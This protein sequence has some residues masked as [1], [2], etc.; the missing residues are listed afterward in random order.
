MFFDKIL[1]PLASERNR[2]KTLEEEACQLKSRV[3]YL[4]QKISD[5]T[6]QIENL[7]E[8]FGESTVSKINEMERIQKQLCKTLNS[9]AST[10]LNRYHEAVNELAELNAL[11]SNTV[12]VNH[13]K[14]NGI[15][16]SL[17][18]LVIFLSLPEEKIYGSVR[19]SDNKFSNILER[20]E[21]FKRDFSN[22]LQSELSTRS[23]T[24][25]ECIY[26]PQ[27]Y[28]NQTVKVFDDDELD[29]E[30]EYA[31]VG[32]GIRMPDSNMNPLLPMICPL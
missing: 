18:S 6:L 2:I 12:T 29:S 13:F 20:I 32:L 30:L 23:K 22:V 19:I 25:S 31:V 4:E 27:S 17:E 5:L 10:A 3:R 8:S 16:K 21:S 26:L 9:N 15:L 7:K 11:L 28:T 1:R 14:R 24:W